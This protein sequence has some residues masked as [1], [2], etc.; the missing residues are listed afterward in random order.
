MNQESKRLN[1]IQS[2]RAI[3]ALMV[4]FFHSWLPIKYFNGFQIPSLESPMY[5]LGSGVDLFFVISGF[6]FFK[7][8]HTSQFN[9]TEFIK[10]RF[11]RIYPN[12]WLITTLVV[13]IHFLVPSTNL[14]NNPY[15]FESILKSYLIFP[16]KIFPILI[17]GWTLE[18]EMVFY[19]LFAVSNAI[20]K[21]KWLIP[22]LILLGLFEPLILWAFSSSTSGVW[23]YR[24]LS[25][26]QWEFAA[27]A[28]IASTSQ[29]KIQSMGWKIPLPISLILLCSAEFF[30]SHNHL[31]YLSLYLKSLG[32][33]LSYSLLL[34]SFLNL[35]EF[36]SKET[37]I[38]KTL[39]KIGEASYSLYLIHWIV[40]SPLGKIASILH[41]STLNFLR[42]PYRLFSIAVTVTIAVLYNMYVEKKLIGLKKYR[43]SFLRRQ[44]I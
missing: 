27:G 42:E 8:T 30:A 18:H 43:P 44:S 29:I 38:N 41:I 39:F 40:L 35:E 28:I 4:V 19:F 7:T 31:P 21:Q 13:V 6:I 25:L 34:I 20:K 22:T 3:A 9:L 5:W 33:T 16:Q 36:F 10:N 23:T 24:F 37:K 11:W 12:Y 2:L 1:S 14:G 15:T 26:Y 17:L 32:V